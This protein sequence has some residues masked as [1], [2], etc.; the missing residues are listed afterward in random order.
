MKP[1][2]PSSFELVFDG[3]CGL[4]RA[5]VWWLQKRDAKGLIRATA[6]VDVTWADRTE[7]PFADTAVLRNEIGD[8]FLR[9]SAVGAAL[10]VLPRGWGAV[11]RIILW[12]N[13]VRAIRALNDA[14]Y[15]LI[16]QR[17][18][19]ISRRLVQLRLLDDGCAVLPS[20]AR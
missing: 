13:R 19:A 15:R 14:A 2:G 17:R 12:G 7:L 6:S 10:A 18:F 9:S 16:A 1:S 3:D 20:E 8:T 5:S 11:G 4:C